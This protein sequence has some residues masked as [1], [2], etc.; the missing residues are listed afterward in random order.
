MTRRW[1][2]PIRSMAMMIRSMTALV[3]WCRGKGDGEGGGK[4]ETRG[5]MIGILVLARELVKVGA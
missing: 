1:L 2:E 5:V 3:Q 4:E